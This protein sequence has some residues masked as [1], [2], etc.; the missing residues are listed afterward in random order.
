ML[1]QATHPLQPSASYVNAW[2]EYDD[3]FSFQNKSPSAL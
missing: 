1:L 3:G 2:A